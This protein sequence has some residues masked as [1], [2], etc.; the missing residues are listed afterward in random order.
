MVPLSLCTTF[1]R[2]QYWTHL[3]EERYPP[4]DYGVLR[5]L[6]FMESWA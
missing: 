5:P 4:Y 6:P 3:T 2:V 1:R